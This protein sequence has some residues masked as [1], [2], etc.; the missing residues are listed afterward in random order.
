MIKFLNMQFKILQS[1]TISNLKVNFSSFGG[2]ECVSIVVWKSNFMAYSVSR[3]SVTSPE[4][5]PWDE[6]D[7]WK[8]VILAKALN[9]RNF[10]MLYGV[11]RKR[12][13][14]NSF[15]GQL[16]RYINGIF[17]S[18]CFYSCVEFIFFH[19]WNYHRN[20]NDFFWIPFLPYYNFHPL[21]H[22]GRF[23]VFLFLLMVT[24]SRH[25][26]NSLQQFCIYYKLLCTGRA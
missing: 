3:Y 7:R 4:I 12:V 11:R 26:L 8:F 1:S 13:W 10:W 25:A 23:H 2:S 19:I 14:V 16:V 22:V 5:L 9:N 24:S 21:L 20:E 15:I 17:L 6:H 18:N